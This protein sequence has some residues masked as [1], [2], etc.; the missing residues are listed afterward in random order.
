MPKQ[1]PPRPSLENLK[2]Q[3]KQILKGHEAANPDV[4]KQIQ[5]HHP[6]FRKSANFFRRLSEA[7]EITAA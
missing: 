1:L 4:L 5:E 6:R 7:T 3:A 2:K